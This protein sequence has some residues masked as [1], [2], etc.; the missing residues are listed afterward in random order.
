M[1][2]VLVPKSALASRNNPLTNAKQKPPMKLEFLIAMYFPSATKHLVSSLTQN[3]GNIS[4]ISNTSFSLKLTV[5]HEELRGREHSSPRGFSLTSY[6]DSG[7]REGRNK[8]RGAE[9]ER[10]PEKT[11]TTYLIILRGQW[12]PNLYSDFL[13]VI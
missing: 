2:Q 5:V 6:D 7:G 9:E 12:F 3:S 4:N 8:V 1:P 13:P 10:R 11:R